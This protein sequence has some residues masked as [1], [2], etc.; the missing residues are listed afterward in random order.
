MQ[1]FDIY[2]K[3]RLAGAEITTWLLARYMDDARAFL[4]PIRHGWR[5]GADGLQ[6]SQG[7]VE[8]DNMLTPTEVIKRVL[9]GS[10]EN[11]EEFLAFTFETCEDFQG[12]LPALDTGLRVEED[13]TVRYNYYEKDTCTKMTIQSKSA[14]N[15]NTKMQILSQDV[16]RRLFNIREELGAANSRA[17]V[18]KYAVK[19]QQ[20]GYTR[21]QMKKILINGI[22]GFE[23]KRR[24]RLA[25]EGKLR[26]TAR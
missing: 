21:E 18:E 10:I 11:V 15:E 13:N 20:S 16:V 25:R 4:P 3:E 26:N 1:M 2:W 23:K 9:A 5:W 17:L 8:E 22:K 19:L 24:S 7:W 6:F 12:W 14:M